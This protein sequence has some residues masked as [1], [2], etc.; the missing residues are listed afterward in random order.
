MKNGRTV[1][2]SLCG[3]SHFVFTGAPMAVVVCGNEHTA[4]TTTATN[5]EKFYLFIL[6]QAIEV[7]LYCFLYLS[8]SFCERGEC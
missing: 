1:N 7:W 4:T 6:V 8:H 3:F 5:D 2:N